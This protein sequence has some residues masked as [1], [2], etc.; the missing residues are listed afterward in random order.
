MQLSFDGDRQLSSWLTVISKLAPAA[1]PL[2]DVELA[3]AAGGA[4]ANVRVATRPLPPS[5]L[6]LHKELVAEFSNSSHWPKHVLVHYRWRDSSQTDEHGGLY[7]FLLLGLL[8]SCALI[9]RAVLSSKVG[10]FLAEGDA[11][12]DTSRAGKHE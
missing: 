2:V 7:S 6:V 11:Q 5:F 12:L 10:V 1:A 9:G 3:H 4:L 8:L